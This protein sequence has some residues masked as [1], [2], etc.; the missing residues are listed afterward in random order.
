MLDKMAATLYGREKILG[1]STVHYPTLCLTEF[2][3]ELCVI[4]IAYRRMMVS[5]TAVTVEPGGAGGELFGI[6]PDLL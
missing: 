5:G 6:G 1:S 2:Q 3:I 4:I